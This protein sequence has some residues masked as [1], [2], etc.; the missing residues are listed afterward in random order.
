MPQRQVLRARRRADRV[1]LDEAE[2]IER[3]L[4]G[5]GREERAGDGEPPQVVEGGWHGRRT[6]VQSAYIVH[7][8]AIDR[9]A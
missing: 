7:A 8:L 2:R 6:L 3:T 9:E 5:R 4:E 1:G